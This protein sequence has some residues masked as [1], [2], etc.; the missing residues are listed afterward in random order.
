MEQPNIVAV[1]MSA[2]VGM[3]VGSIWYAPPVLGK[4]WAKLQGLDFGN[5]SGQ[6]KAM[7]FM[8]LAVL[9]R[10]YILAHF[11][12]LVGITTISGALQLGFWAWLGFVATVLMNDVI[13]AKRSFQ[14]YLINAGYLLVE[15]LV[16]STLL[17]LW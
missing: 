9:L 2:I 6:G 1:F 8:F 14:L 11:V 10:A 3:I 7:V 4:K 5:M 17:S 15:M 13:F 12:L 16:M